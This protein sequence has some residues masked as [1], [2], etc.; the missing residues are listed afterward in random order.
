MATM[1]PIT[2]PASTAM[3]AM[4]PLNTRWMMTMTASVNIA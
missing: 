3:V 4:K 2:R 1:V